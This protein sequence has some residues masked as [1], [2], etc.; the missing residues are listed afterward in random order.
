[1]I[2]AGGIVLLL[3][4]LIVALCSGLHPLAPDDPPAPELEETVR[5]P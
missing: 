5:R 1:M 3:V 2:I 4:V